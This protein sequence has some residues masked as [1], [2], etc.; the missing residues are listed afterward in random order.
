M[1]QLSLVTSLITK[2]N[3]YLFQDV[4]TTA[5]FWLVPEAG[6]WVDIN[7]FARFGYEIVSH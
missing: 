2:I 6:I 1:S 7:V 3:C 5:N 4:I